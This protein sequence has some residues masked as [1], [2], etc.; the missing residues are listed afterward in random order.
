MGAGLLPFLC[1]Y[2]DSTGGLQGWCFLVFQWSIK[3]FS[4]GHSRVIEVTVV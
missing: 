2:L 3:A 1:S 4:Q